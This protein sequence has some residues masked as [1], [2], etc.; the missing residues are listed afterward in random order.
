M[1]LAFKGLA[2]GKAAFGS[3]AA[4]RMQFNEFAPVLET[5]VATGVVAIALR[6]TLPKNQQKKQ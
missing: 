2:A 1:I 5:I 3:A 6:E 4:A